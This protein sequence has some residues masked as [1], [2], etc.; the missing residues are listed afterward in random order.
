[1]WT[2][3]TSFYKFNDQPLV[4]WRKKAKKQV[5]LLIVRLKSPRLPK[6]LKGTYLEIPG[7]GWIAKDELSAQDNRM[8]KVQEILNQNTIKTELQ[9][10]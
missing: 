5:R 10:T 3:R 1:M 8:E 2:E 6:H 4:K 7:Q 9:F